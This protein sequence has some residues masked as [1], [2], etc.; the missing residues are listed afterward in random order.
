MDMVINNHNDVVI[1][2]INPVQEESK[3]MIAKFEDVANQFK[4]VNGLVFVV[5][6]GIRN[7]YQAA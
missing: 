1:M 2:F 4:D 5:I 3:K 6:D 7:E